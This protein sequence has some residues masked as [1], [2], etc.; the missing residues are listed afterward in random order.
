MRKNLLVVAIVLVVLVTVGSTLAVWALPTCWD[1][2]GFT[3]KTSI[4]YE[5][6]YCE[7]GGGP[8]YRYCVAAGGQCQYY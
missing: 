6:A 7:S 4:A 2:F 5:Y 1:C 8:D 3:C